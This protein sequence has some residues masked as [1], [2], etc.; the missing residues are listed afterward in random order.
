MTREI[1]LRPGPVEV[2][3][4]IEDGPTGIS[5]R[6]LALAGFAVMV[7]GGGGL[8]GWA[9]LATLDSAVPATGQLVVQSKRKTVSL[10]ESG[11]LRELQVT[12]GQR[13]AAGDVLMLLDDAQPRALVAQAS[14]RTVAAEARVARLRAEMEDRD[15]PAFPASF[16]PGIDATMAAPLLA[17][18]AALFEARREAYEGAV[19]VQQRR[20]AQLEQQTGGDRETRIFLRADKAVDYG[21]LMEVLNLLRDTGY[22]K[23]G[24]VGLETLPT[25]GSAP[26]AAG[27]P[28]AAGGP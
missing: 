17:A 5:L 12:E 20:T 8:L 13:V 16:G 21:D 4:Q 3:A 22:L 27:A 26:D 18:E 1:S 14:A 15:A 10:L 28:P 23:I 2:T 19:A 11:L 6:R 24:L 25:P 9:A 7:L